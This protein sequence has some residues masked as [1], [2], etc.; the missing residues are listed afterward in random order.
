MYT[1]LKLSLATAI[2]NFKWVKKN[3]NKQCFNKQCSRPYTEQ[4]TTFDVD[5]IDERNETNIE[6][7]FIALLIRKIYGWT[8]FTTDMIQGQ[9]WL[10]H[11]CY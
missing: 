5:H 3:F 1:L 6:D 10:L 8:D 9:Y 4:N 7:T 11:S 2:H